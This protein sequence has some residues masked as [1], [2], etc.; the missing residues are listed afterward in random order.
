MSCVPEDG[1]ASKRR[2][3]LC[4]WGQAPAVPLRQARADCRR[5]RAFSGDLSRLP[6]GSR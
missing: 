4:G 3:S 5:D 6:G 2:D 1:D